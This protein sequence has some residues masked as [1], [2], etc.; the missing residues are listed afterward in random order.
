[1]EEQNV[2]Y[3]E[4]LKCDQAKSETLNK[5]ILE[6]QRKEKL[7]IERSLRVPNKPSLENDAYVVV[8]VCHIILGP[9]TRRFSPTD[10]MESVFAWVGSLSPEPEFF[11]LHLPYGPPLAAEQL[12][13]IA[14]RQTLSNGGNDHSK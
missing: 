1:M 3:E 4:S 12:V 6:L 8:K 10:R 13:S 7:Q 14:D 11:S 5:E 2:A 9:L